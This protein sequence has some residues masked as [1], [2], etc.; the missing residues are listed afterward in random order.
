MEHFTTEELRLI[1]SVF[2]NKAA[3]LAL[4]SKRTSPKAQERYAKYRGIESK[5]YQEVISRSTN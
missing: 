4:P 2:G 5:A 1:C 3:E